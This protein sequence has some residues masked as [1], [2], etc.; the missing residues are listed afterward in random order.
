[1]WV[2]VPGARRRVF[3]F[4]EVISSES[5]VE[6]THEAKSQGKLGQSWKASSRWGSGFVLTSSEPIEAD[7]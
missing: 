7:R 1:V 2:A 3:Y 5:Q 4:A 6:L